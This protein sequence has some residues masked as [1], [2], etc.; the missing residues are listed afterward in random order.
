[1]FRSGTPITN[2]EILSNNEE[3]IV[4]SIPYCSNL[5][6][7]KIH[8]KIFCQFIRNSSV[9]QK[10]VS[11]SATRQFVSNPFA[12]QNYPQE[13]SKATKKELWSKQSIQ[14]EFGLNVRLRKVGRS[15]WLY[16]S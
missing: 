15:V 4:F 9:R 10:L 3:T 12:E 2:V 11:S 1:M 5:G 14:K 7:K 16:H 13:S 6:D 8:K